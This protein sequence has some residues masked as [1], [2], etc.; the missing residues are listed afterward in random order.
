MA[1]GTTGQPDCA[2]PCDERDDADFLPRPRYR[3]ESGA[4]PVDPEV[5]RELI[6]RQLPE[7][8]AQGIFRLIAAYRSWNSAYFDMVAADYIDSGG[9]IGGAFRNAP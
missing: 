7:S 6:A 8:T 4:P 1:S 3:D 9:K 2:D 5:L